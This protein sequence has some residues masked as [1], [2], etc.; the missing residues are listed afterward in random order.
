[1]DFQAKFNWVGVKEGDQ[2]KKGQALLSL[3]TTTLKATLDTADATLRGKASS[4][5]K[6]YDD[7][8]DKKDDESFE[9][10]ETRTLAET[11]KDSAVFS[12][13]IAQ[14]NLRNATLYSPFGGVVTYV[15]NHFAGINILFSEKQIEVVNPDTLYFDVSADQTEVLSLSEGQKAT[16]T[17]DALEME[18]EATITFISLTPSAGDV[19]TVYKIRLEVKD[20]DVKSKL[21]VGMS[22]DAR[23]ET[24]NLKKCYLYHL[25]L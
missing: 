14:E 8:K 2:V 4:L 9:E 12:H 17:F 5:D 24:K 7:L 21:R 6:V 22:G 16:I 10:I 13:I 25:S 19:G 15:A 20:N 11:T 1:M 18:T 3:D 23:F